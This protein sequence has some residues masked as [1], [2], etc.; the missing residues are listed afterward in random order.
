MELRM[1]EDARRALTWSQVHC[2]RHACRAEKG[3]MLREF[4]KATGTN[5]KHT[6]R[7]FSARLR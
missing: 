1:S 2:Y 4:C 7:C 3:V 6:P 5:R